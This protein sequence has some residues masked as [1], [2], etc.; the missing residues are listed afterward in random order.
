VQKESVWSRVNAWLRGD[1][2]DSLAG[3][4]HRTSSPSTSIATPF[5]GER[6][7]GPDDSASVRAAPMGST[8]LSEEGHLEPRASR[9]AK[10]GSTRD[11]L[12]E[13]VSSIKE[14]L[15]SQVK[16]SDVLVDALDRLAEGIEG[17]PAAAKDEQQVLDRIG[18]DLSSGLGALKR[19]ESALAH[20]PK[21]ADAQRETIV[22]MNGELS[23]L[24][25]TDEKIATAL[26]G[27]QQIMVE[28]RDGIGRSAGV[29]RDFRTEMAER[30]EHLAAAIE[31]QV[32]RFLKL[33]VVAVA[34]G[35]LAVV[36]GLIGLLR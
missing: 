35:G 1:P 21:L 17:L 5:A 9:V 10:S 20:L 29:M 28:L 11:G 23:R 31:Q 26:N 22:A 6:N 27:V 33:A 2:V 16:S 32:Q 18:T 7:N 8:R 3:E 36:L 19:L 25:E 4:R 14:H 13:L 24:R 30:H 34:L 15:E 12:E